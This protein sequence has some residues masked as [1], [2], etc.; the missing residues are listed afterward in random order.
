MSITCKQASEYILKQEENKLT[1]SQRWAMWR[2][3][4]ICKACKL[5]YKQN[6]TISNVLSNSPKRKE[7]TLKPEDK[8]A[9]LQTIVEKCK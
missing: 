4:V 1:L 5:F 6:K 9:M 7:L 2:H 3:L 8:K